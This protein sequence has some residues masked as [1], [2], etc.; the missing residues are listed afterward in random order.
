MT[1]DAAGRLLPISGAAAGILW[2]V[3]SVGADIWLDPPD[4]VGDPA[5]V[6]QVFLDREPAAWI[7]ILGSIYLAGAI[8]FFAAAA[9]RAISVSAYG[10]A[11]LGGGVLL[12]VAMVVHQG[13]GKFAVLSA[14]HHHDKESIHTLGYFDAVTWLLLAAGTGVFLLATGIASLQARAIPKWLSVATVILGA[15]AILGPGALVFYVVA[16]VWFIGMSI[17]IS[18]RMKA[19]SSQPHAAH[20]EALDSRR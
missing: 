15:I 8:V 13:I 14:A 5:R 1:N 7:M 2:A 6:E 11:V 20:P 17:A 3:S 16:P 10:S 9:G 18:R 4:S 12:A 19:A